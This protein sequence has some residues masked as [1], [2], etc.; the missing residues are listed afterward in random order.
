MDSKIE[1]SQIDQPIGD[2]KTGEVA[3]YDVQAAVTSQHGLG[4]LEAIKAYP[5]AIFWSLMVAMCVVMEGYDTI[6]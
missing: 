1:D 2:M 3:H 5:M 6:L 4:V